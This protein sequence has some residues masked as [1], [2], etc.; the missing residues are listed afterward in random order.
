MTALKDQLN[1]EIV[2]VSAYYD[3]IS[4]CIDC[5][6]CWK[7]KGCTI[8]DDMAKIYDDDFETVVIASPVYMSNLTGPLMSLASRFQAYY[9]AKRFLHNEMELRKK[10]A[11]LL[12]VGGGD[13]NEETA[14]K[15]AIWM[16]KKMNAVLSP[17]DVVLSLHTD[18]VP[19]KEDALALLKIN[20]IARRINM[21]NTH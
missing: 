17:D 10:T 14:K 15:L 18:A 2:E 21:N 9:A 7:E 12:L 16:F 5:R 4:P 13:G 3:N 1:G 19:A 6:R 20:G 11:V 8:K